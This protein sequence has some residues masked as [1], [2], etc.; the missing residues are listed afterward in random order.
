MIIPTF[1]NPYCPCDD[2]CPN[3][4]PYLNFEL[5]DLV[6]IISMLMFLIFYL[7]KLF[8]LSLSLVLFVPFNA[9]LNTMRNPK[10]NKIDT[11]NIITAEF[12]ST[13]LIVYL[14]R[15]HPHFFLDLLSCYNQ[16]VFNILI[17]FIKHTLKLM[18]FSKAVSKC[19]IKICLKY[20][21]LP[22]DCYPTK[23]V[24][25]WYFSLLMTL[26]LDIHPNP[27]Q[28]ESCKR[29]YKE[30]FLSFCNWNLNTLSKND[31]YRV[32]LLEAHNLIFDYDIISLCETSLNDSFNPDDIKLP[33]YNFVPWNY[34]NGLQNGGVGIFYKD[35]L[36]LRIR[37]FSSL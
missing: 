5:Y 24:A 4:T 36:H 19:L 11:V 3:P 2:D 1:Y 29:D 12:M 30:G 34:P 7:C 22:K 10:I 16:H 23:L 37:L 13:I 9:N 18:L 14:L 31:F 35:H 20:F 33:G 15:Y 27:G 21:S 6:L 26:S 17:L 8:S 25:L 32:S 28:E